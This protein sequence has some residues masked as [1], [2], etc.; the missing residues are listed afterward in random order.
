MLAVEA[1]FQALCDGAENNPDEV[2]DDEG[3]FFFDEA[4]VAAGLDDAGLLRLQNLEDRLQLPSAQEFAEL[5]AGDPER[6]Q[7]DEEGPAAN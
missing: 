3:D 2:E 1:V 5:V 4:E 7:D 6:F